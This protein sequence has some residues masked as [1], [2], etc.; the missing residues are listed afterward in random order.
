MKKFLWMLIWLAAVSACSST[1]TPMPVVLQP[2]STVPIQEQTVATATQIS[3]PTPMP[4]VIQPTPTASVQYHPLDTVTQIQEIDLILAAVASGDEQAVRNLFGFT[5][6]AC[7]T[8]N[9]L[10]GP[11]ECREGEAEGTMVEVLPMLG[12]EGS[13]LR[14]TEVDKFPGLNLIGI[15]A[16]YQVSENAYAEENFSIGDYAIMLTAPENRPGVVL[17]IKNGQIIRVDYIFDPSSV[18]E[19]LQRDAA[20][21]VLSPVK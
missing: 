18:D 5:T 9:A 15:Y 21:I 14:K 19:V 1:P 8:V 12:S 20:N 3:L 13:Y 4:E 17:Q 7:K 2:A 10:G 6:S 11:P 16:I